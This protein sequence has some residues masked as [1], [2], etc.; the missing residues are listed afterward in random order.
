MKEKKSRSN[1]Q[2]HVVGCNDLNALIKRVIEERG[3]NESNMLIR[4]GMDGGGGFMKMWM[5]IF[6]LNSNNQ[7]ETSGYGKRI[8]E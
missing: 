5:S 3:I 1:F 2:Q 7:G 8:Q 6:Q 4:I